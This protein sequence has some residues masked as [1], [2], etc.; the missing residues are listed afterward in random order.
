ML[1]DEINLLGHPIMLVTTKK[2]IH[3]KDAP[4]EGCVRKCCSFWSF[5]YD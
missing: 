3:H 4:L 5:L 1:V 2:S